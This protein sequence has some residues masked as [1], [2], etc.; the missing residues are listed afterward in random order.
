MLT[1]ESCCCPVSYYVH[2][3][4]AEVQQKLSVELVAN[5][6]MQVRMHVKRNKGSLSQTH[7]R[8]NEIVGLCLNLARMQL[9]EQ[10]GMIQYDNTACKQVPSRFSQCCK[11]THP[12]FNARYLTY[13]LQINYQN[14]DNLIGALI[15]AGFDDV[16][17]G[18]VRGI[19]LC[20]D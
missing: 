10:T 1:L 14:K 15:I 2:N 12:L 5:L 20:N 6:V 16:K 9:H 3:L 4:E 11:L 18:Q 13:S 7:A 19:E 17:G 8:G